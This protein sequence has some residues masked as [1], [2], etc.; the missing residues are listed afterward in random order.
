MFNMDED[1][2]P[3]TLEEVAAEEGRAKGSM[4]WFLILAQNRTLWIYP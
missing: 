2:S 1:R 3:D 4:I